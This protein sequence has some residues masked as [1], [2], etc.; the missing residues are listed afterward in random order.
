LLFSFE[1]IYRQYINCRRNKRN[2]INALRFE[3]D[4]ERELLKLA[5]ELSDHTYRPGRSVCFFSD[6]PKLREIFAA[7]FRDRIV[8][9][10]L[11]NYLESLWE[12]VFIHTSYACRQ[13]KGIH[14]GVS[15]LEKYIR[16]I[17][18]NNNC[19]AW[20]LQLDISNYFMSIDKETLYFLVCK[21]CPDPDARWLAKTLIFHDCTINPDLRGNPHLLEQL[22]RHKTLFYTPAGKGLPI[23]NLN[24]QFFANVYLNELDQFVKHTLKCCYYLRYC[25]DF[26]LLAQERGRLEEWEEQIRD[27]LA[28]RLALQLN[29]KMRRLQPVSNGINFLGYIVR[30]NYLLVRKRVVNNFQQ[31]ITLFEK[32]LL[33]RKDRYVVFSYERK[34]LDELFAVISSYL[35][36]C[37][38][39]NS[40]RLLQK[41]WQNNDYL[42]RYFTLDFKT[43]RL[44]RRYLMAGTV[45]TVRHQYGYWQ[46]QFKGDIIFMKVGRFIE[47]YHTPSPTIV[48]LLR[49]VPMK[50]NRR[51]AKL[52]FPVANVWKYLNQAVEGGYNVLF[53]G[54]GK[55]IGRIKQRDLIW[56]FECE[57]RGN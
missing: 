22:P 54:E 51:K 32:R 17:T 21:R 7:D 57:M 6:K 52:G 15:C 24:S 9:H 19:R 25:D 11:V 47:F 16:Q 48:K 4:Q 27:F 43:V 29:Q 12:P 55:R 36:H 46:K 14:K 8:H 10:V 33:Q 41:I 56:R 44:S 30:G 18:R 37:K 2:T 5:T 42:H 13:G 38:H 34:I 40:H 53:V 39:A 31:K 20:Y 49:L 50:D 3:V 26:V 35:G 1:N 45:S 23:G 28:D